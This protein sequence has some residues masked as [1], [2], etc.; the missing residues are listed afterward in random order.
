MELICDLNRS[1]TL[2]IDD[3]RNTHVVA[4]PIH[5]RVELLLTN[6]LHM[7]FIIAI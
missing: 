6:I 2:Q 7:R 4:V 5:V 3:R 1:G